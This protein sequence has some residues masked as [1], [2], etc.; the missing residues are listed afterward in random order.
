MATLFGGGLLF[1]GESGPHAGLGLLADRGRILRVAPLAA[2]EGMAW[3]RID[4][5]GATLMPGLID[6]HVHL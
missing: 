3:T 5:T 4:T 1:D 2:F 6:C